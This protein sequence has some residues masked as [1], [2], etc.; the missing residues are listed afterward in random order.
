MPKER[1]EYVLWGWYHHIREWL[2]VMGGSAAEC[3]TERR[4]RLNDAG[5]VWLS[6]M[7]IGQH[8]AEADQ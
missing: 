5:F 4:F 7:P 8:P 6:I 2:Q 1:K 3:R